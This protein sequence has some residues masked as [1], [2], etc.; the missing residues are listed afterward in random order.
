MTG[1]SARQLAFDALP[2]CS[3]WAPPPTRAAGPP[4]G[5]GKFTENRT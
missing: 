4:I 3:S 2:A 5:L 1:H